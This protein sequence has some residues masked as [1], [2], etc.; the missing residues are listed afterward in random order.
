MCITKAKKSVTIIVTIAIILFSCNTWD[1]YKV[2]YKDSI[3]SVEIENVER[4]KKCK[5]PSNGY[6]IYKCPKCGLKKYVPFTCKC[7]LC[8]SCGTKAANQWANEIHHKLLKVPHRHVIFTI[9]DKLRELL[10]DPK[11]QKILFMA[12]KITMEEMVASS[13][14]KSKQKIKL[15]IGMIQVLQTYGADIKWNPHV[16]CIVTEGGFDRKGNWIHT[17]YMPYKFWRK[18][19]QY[20]LLTMLKKEMPK[21]K[22]NSDFINMLFKNNPEGFVINGERRFEK[23]EGWN[24]ARYIGRYIKH[25]PIG[26]SR[27]T[28]FDGKQVTYWYKDSETKKIITVTMEKFEFIRLLL[29]HLPEKN[30]K[31]VRYVGIY[32]RRG[33]KHRQTE[34][35]DSEMIF[36]K[37]S[38]R[39]EIK[40]T[41]SYDP[42]I[43]PDCNI[44]ME[45]IEI[46]YEGTQS[47]PTEEPPPVEP[48][49]NIKLCQQERIRLIVALIIDNQNGKGASIEKVV[50]EA[51]KKG[52]DREQVLGDIERLK[53][54]GEVYEPKS[55]E[56]KYVF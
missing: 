24:M 49:S 16:H 15:K 1:E 13:N 27:I 41:F 31:I 19:W 8:T 5:T 54:R 20:L 43:C 7:R 47:Y 39:E 23:G 11:Y 36:I 30:F 40:K 4:L 44:E 6:K 50:S 10:R 45:L 56:I 2:R 37:K 53:V 14:K 34:F 46:C 17:Y 29:S 3:R 42:L 55:D 25:P 33:Y 12:S 28:A 48:P 22:E 52:I 51:A 38:W 32:S 9:S 18:K 26:E 21:C 35:H